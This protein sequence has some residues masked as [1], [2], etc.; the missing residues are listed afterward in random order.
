MESEG[1][2]ETSVK[3]YHSARHNNNPPPQKKVTI[4]KTGL[5]KKWLIPRLWVHLSTCSIY[6]PVE[7]SSLTAKLTFV[8]NN[9]LVQVIALKFSDNLILGCKTFCESMVNTDKI[10]KWLSMPLISSVCIIHETVT[11]CSEGVGG[12]HQP[13][14]TKR[15]IAALRRSAHVNNLAEIKG[16]CFIFQAACGFNTGFC[17]KTF[18]TL[19]SSNSARNTN[20]LAWR[21][22]P[23]ATVT[24]TWNRPT[25]RQTD[26][27]Q[28]DQ[29]RP[30]WPPLKLISGSTEKTCTPFWS[31]PK[32]TS[33]L[34]SP[35]WTTK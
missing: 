1:T 34:S 35:K 29:G 18:V 2:S 13:R 21:P 15:Y 16:T 12:D 3:V 4:F 33:W 9:N 17:W 20:K 10:K 11:T 8:Q 24:L 28:R 26:H 6:S 31:R 5:G 19:F 25:D 27:V 23:T 32:L 7:V 30:Y 14:Q 22:D